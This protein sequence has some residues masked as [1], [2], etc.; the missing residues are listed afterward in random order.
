M[1]VPGDPHAPWGFGTL[2]ELSL[3]GHYLQQLHVMT[4]HFEAIAANEGQFPDDASKIAQGSI[5]IDAWEAACLSQFRSMKNVSFVLTDAT[6]QVLQVRGFSDHRLV[7]VQKNY[8]LGGTAPVG[9]AGQP[10]TL[11]GIIRWTTNIAGRSHRGRSYVGGMPA[12]W[13]VNGGLDTN[14]QT[15]LNN[16]ANAMVGT[17]KPPGPNSASAFFTIYSRPYKY[18]AWTFWADGTLNVH[19]AGPYDGNSTGV[20][21]HQIDTVARVQRRRELGVG[22]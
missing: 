21:N 18:S 15:A 5:I 10:G 7:G 3:K 14:G 17:F 9:A 11:A 20:L 2:W 12:E 13:T 4:H 1:A 22:V 8:N 19:E 16:Y 6:C